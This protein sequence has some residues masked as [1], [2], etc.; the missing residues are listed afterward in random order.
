MERNKKETKPSQ[1]RT[2]KFYE[3]ILFSTN[4]TATN[5]YNFMMGFVTYYAVGVAGLAVFLISTLL[6]A[7]RIFDGVVDPF[8]GYVIDKT[9]GKFG[10]F[11]P[12][13]W[14]GN[15][16]MIGTIVLLFQTTHL[17]PENFRLYYFLAVYAVYILGYSLQT[18]V[19]KAGQNVITNDPKQRPLFSMFDGIFTTLFYST[20]GIYVSNYL[21]SKYNGEFGLDFFTEFST[22]FM[23]GS[24]ILTVLATIGI[25]KKDRT[26]FFGLGAENQTD[27]IKFKDYAKIVKENRALQMLTLAA[28][29]DK[30]GS[31]I[32]SNSI[33]GVL[34]FG[35]IIGDYGLMGALSAISILPGIFFNVFG[36]MIARKLGQKRT[37]VLAQSSA[38]L[39]NGLMM[40]V[41]LMG[42]PTKISLSNPNLMTVLF[43][44]LFILAT[45]QNTGDAMQISMISDVTD[46]E[47]ARSGAYVPGLI[48]TIFSFVDNFFSSF[49][50]SIV[51]FVIAMVGYTNTLPEVG[52]ASTPLLI[53]LG[54]G[55]Y[56]GGP[57]LGWLCSMIAMRFYPL[58]GK[59]MEEVQAIIL[60][61]KEKGLITEDIH[62]VTDEFAVI[63]AEI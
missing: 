55:L 16:T 9:D 22:T 45:V 7:M 12:Y 3:I 38:F 41:V 47:T 48:G 31:K 27:N 2:A 33:S 6:T 29:T 46:Y 5:F 8:I 35:I 17:V 32:K 15:L 18:T 61:R 63:K 20:A 39:V 50:N 62:E 42:D 40:L 44:G 28:S 60:E 54:I 51:G 37:Y 13:I 30:L 53:L 49:S 52:D 58:D 24:L 4:N 34:F 59:K 11:R 10:K 57:M 19:T 25:W 26:E 43:V 23:V 56:L 21:S 1:Y 36:S 14:I